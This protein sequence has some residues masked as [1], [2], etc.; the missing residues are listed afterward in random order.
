M[1]KQ[2]DFNFFVNTDCIRCQPEQADESLEALM[3]KYDVRD[4]GTIVTRR[5]APFSQQWID[6]ALDMR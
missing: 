5:P 2:L 4:D 6:T 3:T 1:R